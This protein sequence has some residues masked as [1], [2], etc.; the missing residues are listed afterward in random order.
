MNEKGKSYERN[1]YG[2]LEMM[3]DVGGLVEVLSCTAFILV[4]LFCT[5]SAKVKFIEIFQN[6]LLKGDSLSNDRADNQRVIRS[7]KR[8]KF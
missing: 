4:F 7:L 5:E 8:C 1:V 6:V 3:G 2:L